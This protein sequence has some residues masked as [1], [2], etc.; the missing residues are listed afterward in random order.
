[1]L[2]TKRVSETPAHKLGCNTVLH[3]MQ[4][5]RQQANIAPTEEDVVEESPM[6]ERYPGTYRQHIVRCFY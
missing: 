1:M 3:K 6:K 2:K 4:R 5:L